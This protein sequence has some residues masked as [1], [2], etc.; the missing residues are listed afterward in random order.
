M[1]RPIYQKLKK[2]LLEPRRRIQAL[3]GPRQVGKTTLVE[4]FMEEGL[5]P[6]H[7]ATADEPIVKHRAWIAEQ[8]HY[9]RQLAQKSEALIILD[10]IQKVPQW[11]E[12]VKLLW[13]EDKKNK[14]PLKCVILGSSPLLMQ[15]DLNENLAGQY[16]ITPVMH[17]SFSEMSK[18]FSYSL[19]EYIYYGGYPGAADLIHEFK[20]WKNYIKDSL[21]ETTLSRDILLANRID[22]PALLRQLFYLGSQY[23]GQILSYQKML[24]QL[25]DAGNTTTLSHYLNLLHGCALISGIHKYSP[26]KIQK[27]ASSPKLIVFNMALMTALQDNTLDEI[28]VDPAQWGRL[29]ESVIGSHLLNLQPESN[30]E[31]NYW[32]EGQYEVDFVLTQG[33]KILAIEVKSGKYQPHL[34]GLTAFLKKFPKAKLLSIGKNGMPVKEFLE[35]DSLDTLF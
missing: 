7:Y 3:I 25:H 34:P 20:R 8:W 16:E 35:L 26:K 17:W 2:H 32:K 21:I 27:R 11:S 1:K 33:Q 4:A 22:K 15:T 31:I 12:E 19:D 23:S 14:V 10:E 6:C 9:A 18:A 24:G 28:K 13:D 29:I 5:L 30:I